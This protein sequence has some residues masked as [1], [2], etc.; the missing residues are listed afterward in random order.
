MPSE[1]Q[2]LIRSYTHN[3]WTA[4]LPEGL[5]EEAKCIVDIVQANHHVRITEQKLAKRQIKE[6]VLQTRLYKIQEAMANRLIQVTSSQI[7]QARAGQ[8][9]ISKNRIRPLILQKHDTMQ[10]ST[11][12][13]WYDTIFL[14]PYL[15]LWHDK[16]FLVLWLLWQIW[17][18]QETVL[19]RS[20]FLAQ[21]IQSTVYTCVVFD[22]IQFSMM[23]HSIH[24]EAC[25]PPL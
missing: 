7:G 11:S 8:E 22:Y 19:R 2:S 10:G 21:Y 25:L 5:L 14:F 1:S 24:E 20:Y 4:L 3:I 9:G 23:N 16:F 13:A 12:E 15:F 17:L 18:K 6:S